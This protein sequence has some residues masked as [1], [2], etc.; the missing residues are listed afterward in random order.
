M[1]NGRRTVT[2]SPWLRWKARA[3]WSAATFEAAYGDCAWSGWV[4]RIGR[5]GRRPVDLARR[6]LDDPSDAGAP[7]GL[8]DVERPAHVRVDERLGGDVRVRDRDERGQVEDD[9]DVLGRGRHEPGVADVPE[10]DVERRAGRRRHLVEPAGRRPRVVE[11]ERAHVRPVGDEP[12]DEVAAD[13]P[14]RAGDHDR[15]PAHAHPSPSRA[16]AS[17]SR[18]PTSTQSSSTSNAPT[19]SPRASTRSMTSGMETATPRSTR[20]TTHGSSA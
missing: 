11:A 9:L 5:L 1:L 19:G 17:W 14:V 10:P 6:R 3:S 18:C 13:E 8:E 20:P 12:F 15:S 7:G 2:G 16:R 4:S